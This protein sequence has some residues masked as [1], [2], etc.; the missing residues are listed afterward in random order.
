MIPSLRSSVTWLVVLLVLLMEL[1]EVWSVCC[2]CPARRCSIPQWP[3]CG[4]NA[5]WYSFIYA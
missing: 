4:R 2:S 5:K 1:V 3:C